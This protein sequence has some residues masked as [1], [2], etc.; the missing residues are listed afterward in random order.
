MLLAN[1][2]VMHARGNNSCAQ[3]NQTHTTGASFW[4][5]LMYASGNRIK[6]NFVKLNGDKVNKN[7]SQ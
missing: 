7:M 3:F 2:H 4:I 1:I 5:R 6:I